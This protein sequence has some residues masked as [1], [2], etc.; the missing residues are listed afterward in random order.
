MDLAESSR[1]NHRTAQYSYVGKDLWIPGSEPVLVAG[2]H[3]GDSK[4]CAHVSDSSSDLHSWLSPQ[5]MVP[6]HAPFG[7]AKLGKASVASSSSTKQSRRY[8]THRSWSWLCGLLENC[9]EQSHCDHRLLNQLALFNFINL[10]NGIALS[11]LSQGQILTELQCLPG[12]IAEQQEQ[13]LQVCCAHVA[14]QRAP[15]QHVS[16]S[17]PLYYET[18]FPFEIT[19]VTKGACSC[20][21][22]Q[23][24]DGLQARCTPRIM[25]ISSKLHT[26][27]DGWD[28]A[29][30]SEQNKITLS[31]QGQTQLKRSF[32][33]LWSANPTQ[34][35]VWMVSLERQRLSFVF[36]LKIWDKIWD[37]YLV[38]G[39]ER[40]KKK[41]DKHLHL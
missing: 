30:F 8:L 12:G 17:P 31:A 40:R 41:A 15:T 3:K 18:I 32:K 27:R 28:S 25:A 19:L 26:K 14:A 39:E 34:K 29:A 21:W 1:Q 22:A 20:W 10:T 35:K 2:I 5:A 36:F 13:S 4:V 38:W 9:A 23:A 24:S 16:I 33:D 37:I 6:Y 11:S 7:S